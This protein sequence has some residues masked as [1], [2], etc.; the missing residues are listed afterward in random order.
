[1]SGAAS[2]MCCFV[3]CLHPGEKTNLRIAIWPPSDLPVVQ[4]IAH[5]D[6]FQSVRNGSVEPDMAKEIGRIPPNS[7]CVFC[8]KKLPIIGRHPYAM[9]VYEMETPSRYWA[10]AGCFESA[11]RLESG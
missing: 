2:W 8:G 1:M 9:E 11:I 3:D 7:R 6:C 4:A 5:S 10:H